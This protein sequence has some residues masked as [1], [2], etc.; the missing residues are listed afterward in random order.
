F[1]PPAQIRRNCCLIAPRQTPCP[2]AQ[3]RAMAGNRCKPKR[4]EQE[5]EVRH[6]TPAHKGGRATALQVECLQCALQPLRHFHTMRR[7]GKVERGASDI[8]KYC[9]FPKINRVDNHRQCPM[10]PS[11]LS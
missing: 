7:V 10:S 4:R 6:G 8:K 2:E 11:E 3:L 9:A 5:I 1:E